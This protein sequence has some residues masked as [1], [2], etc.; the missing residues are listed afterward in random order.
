MPT[1]A[2]LSNN[3]IRNVF[4]D[5][6]LAFGTGR[7]EAHLGARELRGADL[8]AGDARKFPVAHQGTS[9]RS[10]FISSVL[11][12]N[13][14]NRNHIFC[15]PERKLR[16]AGPLRSEFGGADRLTTQTAPERSVWLTTVSPRGSC[17]WVETRIVCVHGTP[18]AHVG[19]TITQL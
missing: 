10:R 1:H 11:R 17:H 4:W 9:T 2:R 3:S 6:Y 12:Q 7:A 14:A 8:G 18:S 13:Q 5:S 16:I 15:Q 19:A